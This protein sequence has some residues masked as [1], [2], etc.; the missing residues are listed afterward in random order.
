[1]EEGIQKAIRIYNRLNQRPIIREFEDARSLLLKEMT[2]RKPEIEYYK[3]SNLYD[4]YI[5][6]PYISL[7]FSND[8]IIE[9]Q[10]SFNAIGKNRKR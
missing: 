10:R 8:E 9:K 4:Y 5:E 3:S 2:I 7:E 6:K 1:M